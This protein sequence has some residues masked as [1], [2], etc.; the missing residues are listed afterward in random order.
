[1]SRHTRGSRPDAREHATGDGD[2]RCR[3][4]R[5]SRPS[6]DRGSIGRAMAQA[7]ARRRCHERLALAGVLRHA[8]EHA[9]ELVSGS[10]T[11]RPPFRRGT[12]GSCCSCGPLRFFT[13]EIACRTE[14]LYLEVAQQDDRV[15]E[16]AD[17]RRL[18]H[19]AA[20]HAVLHERHDARHAAVGEIAQQL[21]QLDRRAAAPR[22]SLHV[23]VD[24]VDDDHRA[25]RRFSTASRRPGCANS[26]GDSSVGSIWCMRSCPSVDR[27]VDVHAERLRR[28]AGRCAM[29][30][31][32][33]VE[34]H[35]LAALDRGA[36]VLRRRAPTCP[37]PPRR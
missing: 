2:H 9:L 15:G 36:R 13:T 18:V 7:R 22:A 8:G 20:E 28:A 24:R 25:R 11:R 1:M 34:A 3:S 14:P 35:V 32:E 5:G 21:V 30:L 33:Q 26:P 6:R 12:R 4:A 27:V 37:C 29:P 16:V 10:P 31:V 23:A 17:L 19:R